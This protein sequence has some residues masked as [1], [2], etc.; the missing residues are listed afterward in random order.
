MGAFV[1]A[2]NVLCAGGRGTAQVMATVRAGISRIGNSHLIDRRFD[3]IQMGLVPA[4]VLEPLPPDLAHAPLPAP[5]RRMLQLAAPTLAG[6]A[7]AL[8]EGPVT[9]LLGLAHP[10]PAP[11]A[12]RSRYL[13]DLGLCAGIDVD[14]DKSRLFANGRASSLMAMEAAL[15]TLAQDPQ[16]TIVVGGVDTFFDLRRIA[17]LDAENRILGPKVMDGFIPGEGAGFLVLKGIPDAAGSCTEIL[18]AASV[19]DPGHRYGSEPAKGEGLA[20]ALDKLRAS[21]AGEPGQVG[22]SWSGFNGEHFEAKLWG[23]ARLRHSD[24]FAPDA[25]LQHPADCIGDSG[26]GAGAILGALA[27]WSLRKNLREG[28]A[29]V[30]CASDHGECACALL[31]RV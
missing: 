10:G 20:R 5:V 15:T 30:W 7:D 23:V 1:T 16:A 18:G 25:V 29:L 24:F 17:E 2:S 9:L 11:E 27:D 22:A 28:P 31:R 3:P 19:T 6:L 4:D 21:A 8:P 14:Q 13:T 26:A 12:W